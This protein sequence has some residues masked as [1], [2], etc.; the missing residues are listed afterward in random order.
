MTPSIQLGEKGTRS[1]IGNGFDVDSLTKV[2]P[3]DQSEIFYEI[4]T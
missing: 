4:K 1:R 3:G 2:Y